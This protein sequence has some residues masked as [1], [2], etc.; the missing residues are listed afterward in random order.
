MAGLMTE[1]RET[2]G[3]PLADLSNFIRKFSDKNRVRL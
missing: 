1:I 3:L 2:L